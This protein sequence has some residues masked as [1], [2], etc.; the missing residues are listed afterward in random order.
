VATQR[1]LDELLK[2]LPDADEGLM[3]LERAP[4]KV[5]LDVEAGHRSVHADSNEAPLAELPLTGSPS[6]RRAGGRHSALRPVLL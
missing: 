4:Q 1:K 3:V 6:S 2:A 5:L